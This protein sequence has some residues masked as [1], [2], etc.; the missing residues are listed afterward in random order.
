[1][2]KEERKA[3]RERVKQEHRDRWRAEHGEEMEQRRQVK[4]LHRRLL[5]TPGL[6]AAMAKAA[7]LEKAEPPS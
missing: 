1:M 4:Q 2:T 7:E 5:N 3:E 6:K